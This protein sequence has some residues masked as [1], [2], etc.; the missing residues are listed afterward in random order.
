M[1]Q[2]TCTG[3]FTVCVVK[4]KVKKIICQGNVGG[5]GKPSVSDKHFVYK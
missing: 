5:I 1:R 3:K 2:E 4:R